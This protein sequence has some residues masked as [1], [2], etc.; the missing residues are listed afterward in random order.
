MSNFIQPY[1]TGDVVLIDGE[2]QV[3]AEVSVEGVNSYEYATDR[4]AWYDHQDLTFVRDCDEL[5]IR[6]LVQS[7][8]RLTASLYS[9][10]ERK[11]L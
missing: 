3:I 6:K 9:K 2:E 5:S 10:T 1:R 4:S 11:E 8:E 7:L